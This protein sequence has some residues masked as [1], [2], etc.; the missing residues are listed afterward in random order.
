MKDV[1]LVLLLIAIFG[2]SMVIAQKIVSL[3]I[4]MLA[5]LVFLWLVN[6]AFKRKK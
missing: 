2:F 1:V 3:A 5:F 4:G 6:L